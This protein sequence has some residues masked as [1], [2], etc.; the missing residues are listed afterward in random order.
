MFTREGQITYADVDHE[1]NRDTFGMAVTGSHNWISKL[2][3][4]EDGYFVLGWASNFSD[5]HFGKLTLS[6][7]E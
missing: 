7:K 6:R 4:K 3:G 2:P 1:A 5:I